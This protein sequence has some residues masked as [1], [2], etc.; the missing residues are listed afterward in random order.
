MKQKRIEKRIE[1][2]RQRV[3]REL[4]SVEGLTFGNDVVILHQDAFAGDYQ[5][6]EYK[7]LGML[8]KYIGLSGKQ[9][10]IIGKNRETIDR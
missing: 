3:L 4:P 10:H 5:D 6:S 1:R 7:L 8:I 2:L 9:I